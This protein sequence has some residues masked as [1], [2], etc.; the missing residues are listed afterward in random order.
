MKKHFNLKN[1]IFYVFVFILSFF[2]I[3]ELLQPKTT[4]R[5]FG[6]KGFAVASGSMEPI[7]MTGDYIIM[8]GVNP[9]TLEKDDIVSFYAYLPT[10]SG[11]RSKEIVT[12]YI[13]ERVELDGE[14]HYITYSELDVNPKDGI[15]DIDAWRDQNSQPTVITPDDIIGI[16]QFRIP[17][18]GVIIL[19]ANKIISNPILLGLII[20]NVSIV[21]I[22]VKYIFKKPKEELK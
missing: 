7:I 10:T 14:I 2:I 17:I 12:H 16:Y 15:K 22:L 13:Y 19:E 21:V 11:G 6:F 20:V 9:E 1:I 4:I 18:L 3:A 8:T 5:I